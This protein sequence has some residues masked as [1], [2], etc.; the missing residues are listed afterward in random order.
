MLLYLL[1]IQ[2]ND[3]FL[4]IPMMWIISLLAA[5]LAQVNENST[6]E[7]RRMAAFDHRTQLDNR[8]EFDRR[9]AHATRSNFAVLAIDVDGLKS[10]ND[11]FG[12][13]AGDEVLCAVARGTRKAVRAGDV[14]AR[15]GGDEFGAI[16]FGADAATAEDVAERVC[17]VIRVEAVPQGAARVSVGWA[18]A[19]SS[20]LA[21]ARSEEDTKGAAAMARHA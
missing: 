7:H 4:E 16:L 17:E 12:H 3:D 20:E 2:G 9:L 13:E 10:I 8:R 18:T 14:V 21:A 19:D 5:G 1:Y 11:A 15:T 6:Q